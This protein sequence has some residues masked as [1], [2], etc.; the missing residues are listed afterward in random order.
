MHNGGKGNFR[1][2]LKKFLLTYCL[3][4]EHPPLTREARVLFPGRVIPKTLKMEHAAVVRDAPH[5]QWSKGK[6]ARESQ[7]EKSRG[8]LDLN[9][10]VGNWAVKPHVTNSMHVFLR[11]NLVK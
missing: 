9:Q 8:R 4:V 6:Q 5:K 3:A 11:K 7:L 1:D 2:C 10:L